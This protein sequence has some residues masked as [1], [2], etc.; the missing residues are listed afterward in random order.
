MSGTSIQSDE[1]LGR[2]VTD[3]RNFKKIQANKG[4]AHPCPYQVFKSKPTEAEI[5]V[6]RLD[7]AP[8]EE[9]AKVAKRITGENNKVFYG[10]GVIIYRSLPQGFKAYPSPDEDALNDYH[11]SLYSPYQI[12]D[13]SEEKDQREFFARKLAAKATWLPW[14][15]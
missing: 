4:K 9:V 7:L 11:A 5:S 8:I 12:S 10:W 3:S 1:R 15:K 13:G 6:D 2:R 14:P